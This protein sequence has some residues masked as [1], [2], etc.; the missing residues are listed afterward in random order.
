MLTLTNKISEKT[1]A[2]AASIGPVTTDLIYVTGT[3]P[4]ATIKPTPNG[5]F[6]SFL[7]VVP[8]TDV[9]TTTTGNIAIAVT[10]PALRV[11]I[12]VWSKA[13]AKWY[14]GAIS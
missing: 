5:G 8:A 10:M 6:S 3:T 9:A 1:V 14:P 13:L 2:S 11:T 12:L 7:L 4:I